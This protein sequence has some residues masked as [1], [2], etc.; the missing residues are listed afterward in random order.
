MK[1]INVVSIVG[2][3]S[4]AIAFSLNITNGDTMNAVVNILSIVIITACGFNE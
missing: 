3:I 1:W 2:L 4:G